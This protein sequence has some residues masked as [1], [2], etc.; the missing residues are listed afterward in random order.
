MLLES[1]DNIEKVGEVRHR[2]SRIAP[3]LCKICKHQEIYVWG[4]NQSCTVV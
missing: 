3:T 4:A 1:I 2:V